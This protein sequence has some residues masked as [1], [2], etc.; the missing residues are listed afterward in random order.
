MLM[1]ISL[2]IL[3]DIGEPA[4]NDG[5]K[6]DK[7]KTKTN[8][9]R[10]LHSSM[11]CSVH[12]SRHLYLFSFYTCTF[13]YIYIHRHI[14]SHVSSA[15]ETCF[16][17]VVCQVRCTKDNPNRSSSQNIHQWLHD[18]SNASVKMFNQPQRPS[19]PWNLGVLDCCVY[20]WLDDSSSLL[21]YLDI[22]IYI[23]IRRDI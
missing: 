19:R 8:L 12:T 14:S 22:Y 10:L 4:R 13:I 20:P 5:E 9:S 23:Y 7:S 17:P 6:L 15:H 18:C 2:T 21:L 11:F 1:Q 16:N 3:K